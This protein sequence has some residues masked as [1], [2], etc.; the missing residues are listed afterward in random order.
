MRATGF[1]RSQITRL[2]LSEHAGLLLL[3]VGIGVVAALCAVLPQS[4]TT[5]VH[6]PWG[7]LSGVILTIIAVGLLTGLF[8][9]WPVMRLPLVTSLKDE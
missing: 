7:T 2:V 5:E 6:P 4:L 3:G 1:S 8:A 9:L